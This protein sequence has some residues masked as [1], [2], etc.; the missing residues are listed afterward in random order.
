[1]KWGD[2]QNNLCESPKPAFYLNQQSVSKQRC[3]WK[4]WFCLLP[5][6]PTAGPLKAIMNIW[7]VLTGPG[8]TWRSLVTSRPKSPSQPWPSVMP[9]ETS[10]PSRASMWHVSRSCPGCSERIHWNLVSG[11]MNSETLKLMHK[12]RCGNKDMDKK[13]RA[14]R[15][16]TQGS[17]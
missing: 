5:P 3:C 8:S 10:R 11:D 13:D 6:P 14:K 16:V 17:M 2:I 4:L 15:Y 9:L 7:P 12:R 1:M